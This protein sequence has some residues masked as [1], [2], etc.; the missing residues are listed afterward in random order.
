MNENWIC[1]WDYGDD[2]KNVYA[3][4]DDVCGDF[5]DGDGEHKKRHSMK[6][7]W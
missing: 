6:M 7:S 2:M 4:C 3:R 1:I 5:S